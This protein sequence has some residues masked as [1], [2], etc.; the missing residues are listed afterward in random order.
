MANTVSIISYGNTFGEL[1]TVQNALAREN[2]ALAANNYTKDTGTLFLND[3]GLGLQVAN[4][5]IIEGGLDASY[6]NFET[7][8]RVQNQLYLTNTSIGLTNYGQANVYGLLF[9]NASG[10]SIVATNNITVGGNTFIT[11]N[12]YSSNNI[13][14][15]GRASIGGSTVITGSVN[16]ANTLLVTQNSYVQG[17]TVTNKLVANTTTQTPTAIVTDLLDVST[18]LGQFNSVAS[19]TATVSTGYINT[20]QSNTL[21]NAAFTNTTTLYA[22]SLS[23]PRANV[24]GVIDANGASAFLNNLQVNNQFGVQGNFVISGTTVY[25]SNTFTL[26]SG[27]DIGLNSTY[28]VNR[29]SSGANAGIRW[30][31]TQQYWDL[32]DVNTGTYY[33]LLTTQQI[34]NTLT[35]TSTVQA[36]SA[37]TANALNTLLN[38]TNTRLSYQ[39]SDVGVYANGAFGRANAAFESANN[40]APQ[41]APAYGRANASY[42]RANTSSNTFVGTTGQITP[43]NGSITFNSTNGLTITGTG[44]TFTFNTPQA[45]SST[46]S[47]TFNSLTLRNALDITQG[48]TGAQDNVTALQNLLPTTVGVPAGYVLGT[49]G[50]LGASFSWVAA[51]SGGGGGSVGTKITTNRLVY[52]AAQN[53]RDFTTPTYEAGSGQLRVYVNGVRQYLADYTEIS[54]T[55]VRMNTTLNSGDTVMVEVDGYYEYTYYANTIPFTAPYGGIVSSANTVQLAVQDIETRKAPLTSPSFIG[56][57]TAPKA[58]LTTSNTQIAVTSWVT[59]WANSGYTLS[60][61]ITGNAGSVTNGVYTNGSYSNPDWLTITKAK[62]GL[63]N[64]DNTADRDKNVNIANTAN[65]AVTATAVTGITLQSGLGTTSGPQFGSLGVGTAASGTT[66]EIRATNNITAYYGQSDKRLK[67]NIVPMTGA[68]ANVDKLG[69]YNFNFKTRP[70][71]KMIGVIAQELKEVYPELVYEITP[72]DENTGLDKSL[73]VNYELLSVVLL[74]AIKELKSEVEELKGQ[75]K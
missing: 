65:V 48:G 26:N 33:Q 21:I 61:S 73:A 51:P 50:G 5:V 29:G 71:Q 64:V 55:S 25:N 24:T 45:L 19:N 39:V 69:A 2:N 37:N 40:V 60:H 7:N 11:G 31:E 67:E 20:L 56:V 36:A 15:S 34:N 53:Q 74:Q 14:V 23:T 13:F 52:T 75:I 43:A 1:V 49:T 3:P 28:I 63:G 10:N 44:N 41:I 58:A 46:S 27:S 6:G 57:P 68:L 4:N 18:G 30:N 70:D 17:I 47:P 38:T 32:N 12:V 66:G 42:D 16:V 35:S 59:D 8:L 62:V 72:I 22:Q 9:A 54:T